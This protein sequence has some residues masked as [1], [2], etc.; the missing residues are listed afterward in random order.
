M[1]E[2]IYHSSST[3]DKVEK[4]KDLKDAIMGNQNSPATEP[5][6][7]YLEDGAMAVLMDNIPTNPVEPESPEPE[8][9]IQDPCKDLIELRI[10]KVW[11]G[12]DEKDRPNEVVFHI[13]RSYKVGEDIIEDTTFNE[14]VILKK[15]TCRHR[16]YG[17]RFFPKG[18][19][20]PHTMWVRM[21]RNTT[22]P[23]R[24][25]RQRLTVIQPR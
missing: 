25:V 24:L 19:S 16:I 1:G 15:R 21:E 23:I 2:Y 10:K 6:N 22:I 20:L 9:D 7:V 11:K 5:A 13:T 14:E 3:K 17:K 18:Q 4:F 8:P 12:D